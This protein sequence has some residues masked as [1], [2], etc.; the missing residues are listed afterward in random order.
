MS[1]QTTSETYWLLGPHT[2]STDDARGFWQAGV[3]GTISIAVIV[4]ELT[5]QLSYMLPIL[6]GVVVARA[7]AT[8]F[9]SSIYDT[10]AADKRLPVM[11]ILY[12][13]RSYLHVALCFYLALAFMR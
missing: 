3:T 11:P 6:L 9:S 1:L 5:S 10:I 13:Q 12:H 2:H 8:L 4:F 7:V